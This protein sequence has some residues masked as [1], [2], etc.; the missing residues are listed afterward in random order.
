MIKILDS[1]TAVLFYVDVVGFVRRCRDDPSYHCGEFICAFNN[2]T[3]NP[4]PPWG[5]EQLPSRNVFPV[6]V[7][8]IKCIVGAV[9]DPPIS[10]L[11]RGT[12]AGA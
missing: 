3:P 8:K 10:P 9:N 2:L 12:L 6:L 1:L 5:G 7:Y 4:S 11:V